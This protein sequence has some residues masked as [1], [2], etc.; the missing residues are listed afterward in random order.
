MVT[1]EFTNVNADELRAY[2]HG[3]QESEYL[4]VDVRQHNEYQAGHIAGAR[5]LPLGELSARLSE[6][7]MD[8]DIIFY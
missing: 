3:H 4:L 5:L 8:R 7:P 1:M 2:M 6:L